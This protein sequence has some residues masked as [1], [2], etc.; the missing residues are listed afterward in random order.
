MG[1]AAIAVAT[2]GGDKCH[3]V[4]VGF[5]KENAV[6]VVPGVCDWKIVYGAYSFMS[7]LLHFG[8]LVN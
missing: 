7:I 5:E 1:V 3:Q 4:A 2:P 6:I 8:K